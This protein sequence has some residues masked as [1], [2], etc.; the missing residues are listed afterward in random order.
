MEM[1]VELATAKSATQAITRYQ[2]GCIPY[3]KVDG[4]IQVL[5]VKKTSKNAWWGFC[6]GGLESHLDKRENAAKECFEESGVTGTVTKKIG[7]FKYVKDNV[8]QLVYMYAMDFHTEFES[9]PEQKTRR[10]KWFTLAE[11]RD[12]LSRE[13][14]GFLDKIRELAG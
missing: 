4:V 7:Q 2:S 11:A 5:L 9:W 13:H 6:K 8:K 3:R 1:T 14:H 10:R 12:K